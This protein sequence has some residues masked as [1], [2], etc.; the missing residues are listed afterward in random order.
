MKPKLAAMVAMLFP[1]RSE[2][3]RFSR[4]SCSCRL[5]SRCVPG[6]E[7][8]SCHSGAYVACKSFD[9]K[10]GMLLSNRGEGRR[11]A[12]E[13]CLSQQLALW[14]PGDLKITIYKYNSVQH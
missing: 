5:L 3:V 13:S 8:V 6:R 7:T 4:N 12:N 11:I 2:L 9:T 1:R 10:D 14:M